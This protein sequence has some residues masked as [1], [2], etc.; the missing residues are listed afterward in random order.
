MLRGWSLRRRLV[1]TV[2]VV[3]IGAIV[4]VDVA[5]Y[6]S[7]ESSLL[8]R[9]DH[10]LEQV[11]QSPPPGDR[12]PDPPGQPPRPANQRATPAGTW[13]AVYTNPDSSGDYGDPSE[14]VVAGVS[15]ETVDDRDRPELAPTAAQLADLMDDPQTLAAVSGDTNFRVAARNLRGDDVLVVAMPMTDLDETL[16]RLLRIELIVSSIAGIGV[17]V[18]ALITVR[19]GLRPLTAIATAASEI[20][21]DAEGSGIGRRVPADASAST[22]VGR[23]AASLNGMLD[24]IDDSFAA[25]Q[26]TQQQLRRFVADASHELRT[27]LTSIQGFAELARTRA[28]DMSDEERTTALQRVEEEAQHLA[29]LVEDMLLLSRLDEGLPMHPADVDV[30]QI[31]AASVDAARVIEPARSVQFDSEGAVTMRADP[32]RVRQLL[33]NLLAN[34]RTHAGQDASVQVRVA[35]GPDGVGVRIDVVDT[36]V[37]IPD[38]EHA[39]ATGRFWRADSARTRSTGG[40][41][42]GLAIVSSIAEAHGG[43][44]VIEPGADGRGLA[45]T[46]VLATA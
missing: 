26:A 38:G 36:G 3:A 23:L 19:A 2:A 10:Q 6:R 11:V 5:T 45:V 29:R 37:G 28:A 9:L 12:R 7:L 13:M 14:E 21:H 1:A 16:D 15:D 32:V 20:T 44:V 30:A 40:S 8:A 41:G 46:V 31:V 24:R 18:L 39:A 43:S 35:P 22:E 34:V 4:V 33:D 27:P 42:L 17:I 25:Q